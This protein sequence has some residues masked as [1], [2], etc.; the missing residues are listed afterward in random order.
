MSSISS[1]S[2]DITLNTTRMPDFNKIL[3]QAQEMQLAHWLP[4]FVLVL[5]AVC[6]E[7]RLLVIAREATKKT[8]G[9]FREGHFRKICLA[10]SM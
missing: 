9:V 7:P 8:Q 2:T 1:S 3:E 6:L 5:V 10:A 4:H